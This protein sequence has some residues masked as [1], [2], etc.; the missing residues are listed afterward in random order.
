[1]V[2]LKL[3]FIPQR[4]LWRFGIEV[5]LV[6]MEMLERSVESELHILVGVKVG[7]LDGVFQQFY[8]R[9]TIIGFSLSFLLVLC[10]LPF[11]QVLELS[12]ESLFVR[13]LGE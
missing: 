12:L 5:H 4:I 2:E 3:L 7:A 13:N 9:N 6:E 1:M 10:L 8:W 11:L